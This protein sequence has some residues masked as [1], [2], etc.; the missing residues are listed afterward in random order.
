MSKRDSF[1]WLAMMLAVF[2]AVSL[3]ACGDSSGAAVEPPQERTIHL[4]AI[5]PKGSTSIDSEPFPAKVLP[6]GDGYALKSPD[7]AGK[8]VVETYRFTP[9]TVVVNEGDSVTLEIIGI[10]GRE[11]PFNIE[12]YDVSGVV[13]RGEITRVNFVADKPGLFKLVCEIHTPSM[14]VDMVVLKR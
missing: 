9:G 3:A 10:N 7:D 5:E 11:H 4:A 1:G 12:G 2:M 6:D 8:W 13:K 14:E